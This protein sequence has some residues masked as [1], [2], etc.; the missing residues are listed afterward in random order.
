MD[1][2]TLVA[3]GETTTKYTLLFQESIFPLNVNL[4]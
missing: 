4:D 3:C 2:D 1:W